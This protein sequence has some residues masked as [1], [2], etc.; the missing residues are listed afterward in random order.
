MLLDSF[1]QLLFGYN[2]FGSK[3]ASNNRLSSLF[4]DELILGSY[5]TKTPSY[6]YVYNIYP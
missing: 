5:I 4:D 3:I 6:N 2:I 1:I